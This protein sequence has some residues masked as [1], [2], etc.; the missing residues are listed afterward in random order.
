MHVYNLHVLPMLC[1]CPWPS[2]CVKLGSGPDFGFVCILHLDQLHFLLTQIYSPPWTKEGLCQRWRLLQ[3]A[4]HEC[5]PL[6]REPHRRL[7]DQH[8]L[9]L[10]RWLRHNGRLGCGAVWDWANA[11]VCAS[12]PWGVWLRVCAWLCSTGEG[13]LRLLQEP[14]HADRLELCDILSRG[15]STRELESWGEHRFVLNGW[16]LLELQ[17]KVSPIS[18][19]AND[20]PHDSVSASATPWDNCSFIC[21]VEKILQT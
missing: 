19:P 10:R 4:V 20:S 13:V 2:T 11:G 8:I 9:F 16:V 18:F 7:A 14:A 5:A 15:R 17:A 1:L 21:P 3:L 6:G 12:Y